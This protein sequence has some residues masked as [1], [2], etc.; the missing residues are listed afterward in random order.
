MRKL[1]AVGRTLP[2]LRGINR[3]REGGESH[4]WA[5]LGSC[6]KA[7][8]FRPWFDSRMCSRLCCV[9]R[10]LCAHSLASHYC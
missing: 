9:P 10:L 8:E 2:G 4:D 7:L 1:Q 6:L 3:I 5:L